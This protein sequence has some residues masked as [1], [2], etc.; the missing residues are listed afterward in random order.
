LYNNLGFIDFG[1]VRHILAF[2]RPL[3]H[4]IAAVRDG[5]R[6]AHLG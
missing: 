6:I 2:L 4:R 3:A 1:F 5:I